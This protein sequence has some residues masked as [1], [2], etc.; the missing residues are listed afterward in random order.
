[1]NDAGL[2]SPEASDALV[3]VC[4]ITRPEDAAFAASCGA[5]FV[6]LNFW[7]SSRRYLP[8]EKAGEVARAAAPALLVGVFVDASEEEVEA[9]Q[10]AAGLDLV[11]LHGDEPRE[12]V[13]ALGS[14]AL[15]VVRLTA[16]QLAV[17]QEDAGEQ[18]RALAEDLAAD[19]S[20]GFV[21]ELAHQDYGG[22]GR[23]WDVAAL[24]PLARQLQ[25]LHYRRPAL[26]A[27]GIR[28]ENARSR[29][30]A[31]GFHHLPGGGVDLASGVESAPGI[32]SDQRVRELFDALRR[33]QAPTRAGLS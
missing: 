21:V 27:G 31:S 12:Q 30:V 23:T 9:A 26:L 14:R 1:M 20:A 5:A 4:G 13:A 28:P 2:G 7:P 29:L 19:S 32:K 25:E 33:A 6:G 17:A 8:L 16:Q 22:V 24:V 18:W 15:R 10:A 3:K 11:Q